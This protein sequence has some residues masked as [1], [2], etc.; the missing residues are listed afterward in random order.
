MSLYTT[1][2]RRKSGKNRIM[3]FTSSWRR[4]CDI[5][6]VKSY[7]AQITAG[8]VSLQLCE[9]LLYTGLCSLHVV[10]T[11]AVQWLRRRLAVI[12]IHT[13]S[14]WDDCEWPWWI[15]T[16]SNKNSIWNIS[17]RDTGYLK[18]IFDYIHV[19]GLMSLDSFLYL[20]KTN[21]KVAY[22]WIRNYI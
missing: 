5:S 3:L 6:D 11:R 21:Q 14:W 1:L 16:H 7:G 2:P 13:I 17:K 18:W 12:H 8:L 19:Q 15:L 22:A 4:A 9:Y 20:C 10:H